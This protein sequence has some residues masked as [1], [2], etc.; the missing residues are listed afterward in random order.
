M[1]NALGRCRHGHARTD[2]NTYV[3]PTGVR[4]C[5]ACHR[6]RVRRENEA[7]YLPAHQRIEVLNDAARLRERYVGRGMSIAAIAAELGCTPKPVRLAMRRHGI[8]LQRR[9]APA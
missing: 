7:G 6:E 2:E 1:T 5:R 8:E 4:E 9:R 3:R